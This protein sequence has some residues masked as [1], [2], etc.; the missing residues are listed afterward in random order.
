MEYGVARIYHPHDG[1]NLGLE[2]MIHDL[3]ERTLAD[4][5][6]PG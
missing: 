5:H 2:A 1:M 4:R 6:I 3:I